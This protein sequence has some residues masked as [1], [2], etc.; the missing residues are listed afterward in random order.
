VQRECFQASESLERIHG[1]AP[2]GLRGGLDRFLG[3][4]HPDD[5]GHLER[6]VRQ[7]VNEGKGFT[8]EY[9]VNRGDGEVAWMEV[10]SHLFRGDGD[11]PMRLAGICVD[12]S[13]R[14]QADQRFRW[15]VEAST[16][17]VV[18]V[19]SAGRIIL[20]N[21]RVRQVF[22]YDPGELIGKSVDLLVPER[23]RGRHPGFRAAF[24]QDPIARPMGAG[25][26]LFGLR[27]DGSEVPVEIGLSPIR[28]EEGLLVLSTIVDIT[29]R[30]QAENERLQL[31]EAERAA[32]GEA[33]RANRIKDMFLATVSHEL[34]TPLNAILGWSQLLARSNLAGEAGQAVS[35]IQR[36]ARVQARLI[37]DLLDMSRI[38][39][40]KIRLEMQTVELPLVV[41]SAVDVVL[42]AAQI[43]GIEI[44]KI[45]DPSTGGV[46]GDPNRLQ[47]VVWNLLSNAIKFTPKGGR[48]SVAVRPAGGLAEIV[49]S[50]SGSGIKPDFL[51]FL[52]DRFRQA[53][54]TTTRIH[55]GLGLGL[56]IVKHL[57]ELHG[58]SIEACSDGE[59]KGAV[60]RVSLPVIAGAAGRDTPAEPGAATISTVFAGASCGPQVLAD[61]KVLV[62]DDDPDACIL[63]QRV[64]EDCGANVTTASS[65]DEALA[66]YEPLHPDVIISDISMPGQDGYQFIQ[67]VR[68]REAGAP[69]PTPA[70]ALTALTRPE[71]RARALIAGYQ[72][73]IAKPL[74][75]AELIA[76]VASLTGRIPELNDAAESHRPPGPAASRFP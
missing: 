10:K 64:L 27:R 34:R 4:V 18:L 63:A 71:D 73:H 24:G 19:D 5:R 53:D 3:G 25:R 1:A 17:A 30:K 60:F 54:G 29:E 22:G 51:P 66:A 39:S 42:P 7:A 70:A 33:E 49:V 50:D 28:T 14:R 48:V 69:R 35:V 72:A 41:S 75:A 40:G 13:R 16:S 11:R 32:R 26:D 2:G 65:A 67:E 68:D 36:N 20:A 44:N 47:Q 58:G 59:G 38:I 21:S 43:K 37:E 74:A 8:L 31:L 52:F 57:V 62:V 45:I 6:A 9:R 12:V 46:R 76:V 55:A 23:F 61:L 56:S 15:A